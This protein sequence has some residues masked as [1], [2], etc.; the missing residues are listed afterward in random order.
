MSREGSTDNSLKK[1]N[2]KRGRAEPVA[3]RESGSVPTCLMRMQRGKTK[4]E[5][6]GKGRRYKGPEEEQMQEYRRDA[7]CREVC[8]PSTGKGLLP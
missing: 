6:N 3:G 8:Q 7:E 2:P 5:G 4:C 1:T